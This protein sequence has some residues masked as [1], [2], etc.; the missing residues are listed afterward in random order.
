MQV[1]VKNKIYS[2][3]GTQVKD[4][5]RERV[6]ALIRGK[7]KTTVT[8]GLIREPGTYVCLCVYVYVYMHG[9]VCV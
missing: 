5:P 9:H 2:V 7:P 1:F 8:I 3:G 6:E 4:L